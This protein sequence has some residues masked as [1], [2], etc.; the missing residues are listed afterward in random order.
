MK[1]SRTQIEEELESKSKEVIKKLL[2]W[3]ET[4]N[5]PDLT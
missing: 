3:N 1:K 4:H 2:D 5:E